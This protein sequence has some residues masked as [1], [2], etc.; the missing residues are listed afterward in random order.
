[1]QPSGQ[2]LGPEGLTRKIFHD[3]ELARGAG[4][5]HQLAVAI[6]PDLWREIRRT[7]P[8][9]TFCILSKGCSSQGTR[10]FLLKAV[11]K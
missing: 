5:L 7:I 8:V 6:M 1:M 10:F 2:N 3:K 4:A 11:E 9:W